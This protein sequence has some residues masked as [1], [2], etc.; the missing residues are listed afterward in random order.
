[1]V[2]SREVSSPARPPARSRARSSAG[3]TGYRYLLAV[4]V[5]VVLATGPMVLAVAAGLTT[6]TGSPSPNPEPFHQPDRELRVM[7]GD[8]SPP[9]QHDRGGVEYR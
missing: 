6:L 7:V 1:M 2:T 3:L 5:L 8:D 9:E 4:L